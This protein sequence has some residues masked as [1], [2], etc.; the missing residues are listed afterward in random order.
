MATEYLE[1]PLKNGKP[2]KINYD[3]F[4][5]VR[6][7]LESFLEDED[8]MNNRRFAKKVL[9][10][11]EIKSNNTIEGIT[12]DLLIIEKV[13]SD[14][15]CIK[16][17]KQRKRIINLYNGYKYILT[18]K[19]IDEKHLKELYGILSDGL[20]EKCDIVKMGDLYREDIVYILKNGR[21]DIEPDQGLPFDL[22]P[23]YMKIYFD[24]VNSNMNSDSTMTDYFIKSQVMHFYFVYIHPYFDVNGRSSR[25]MAMWYLLK[26]N[27]YPCIIFNR[28]ITFEASNYDKAIIDTKK[29]CDLTFFIKYMMVNV[30]R[31]FEKEM[32]MH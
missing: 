13:I 2:L 20:L 8:Y 30:K 21:L 4:N 12:D 29:F 1:L 28:A 7:E 19:T 15:S 32:I 25:T 6:E 9:F 10:S 14:A 5:D 27:I 23:K 18:H 31:E 16:D 26:N 11:Q 22:V 24:Y 17:V 3:K